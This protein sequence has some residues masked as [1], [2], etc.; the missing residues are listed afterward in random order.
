MSRLE[1]AEPVLGVALVLLA[2]EWVEHRELAFDLARL[3]LLFYVLANRLQ[4]SLDIELFDKIREVFDIVFII[5]LGVFLK[6]NEL[7]N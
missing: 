6:Y 4:L 3:L 5:H 2:D 1:F 7:V